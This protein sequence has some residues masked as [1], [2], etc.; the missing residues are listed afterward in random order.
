MKNTKYYYYYY[1]STLIVL[2]VAVLY[3]VYVHRQEVQKINQMVIIPK[4][5]KVNRIEFPTGKGG[6]HH[7]KITTINNF[8]PNKLAN[9]L[10]SQLKKKYNKTN[11]SDLLLLSNKSASSIHL[12]SIE[13]LAEYENWVYTSN[14]GG[15]NKKIR[16]NNHIVDRHI[17]ATNLAANGRFSYS[18][19]ELSP[20]SKS[21]KEI[22]NRVRLFL[23]DKNTRR[24]IENIMDNSRDNKRPDKI[25][26][27]TDIFI[28]L[29]EKGQFLSAHNDENSGSLAVV[30]SL[31]KNWKSTYGGN[32]DFFCLVSAHTL[33]QHNKQV[34]YH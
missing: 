29:Y 23:S 1:V 18:K 8:M 24:A 5:W 14:T 9:K 7:I 12:N 28:T 19:F 25:V 3:K 6:N 16:S 33:S 26:G 20:K 31:S 15:G 13:S 17:V 2:I 22:L 27:I 11:K 10:Y 34:S 21:S 4:R 32:L 30:L